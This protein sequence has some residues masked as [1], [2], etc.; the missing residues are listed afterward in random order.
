MSTKKNIQIE[1]FSVNEVLFADRLAKMMGYT[2][3]TTPNGRGGFISIKLSSNNKID[4]D[5]IQT[6][7][8]NFY[9]RFGKKIISEYSHVGEVYNVLLTKKM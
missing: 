4:N 1:S 9:K 5:E 3:T 8:K 6:L 2:R 7:S